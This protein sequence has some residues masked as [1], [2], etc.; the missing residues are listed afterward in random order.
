MDNSTAIILYVPPHTRL[1]DS[2]EM[3]F[4]V[5]DVPFEPPAEHEF[6]VSSETFERFVQYADCGECEE[7]IQYLEE[8][9]FIS[10]INDKEVWYYPEGRPK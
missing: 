3:F 10:D 4:E 8:R 1:V 7:V 2:M 9:F 6:V 5:L